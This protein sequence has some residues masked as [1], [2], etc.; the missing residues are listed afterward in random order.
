MTWLWRPARCRRRRSIG[1]SR[2]RKQRG[3]L[4]TEQGRRDQELALAVGQTGARHSR[5]GR[6]PARRPAAS[7]TSAAVA[8]SKPS[9][10]ARP[11]SRLTGSPEQLGGGRVGLDHLVARGIDDQHRLGGHLEQQAVA[12]LD[13]PQPG[14][15][16]LHRLLRVDQPLLQG[17]HGAQVA[18]DRHD[19]ARRRRPAASNRGPG[20]R[21]RAARDG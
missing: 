10:K 5:P 2:T 16:A 20:G 18:A 9:G 1:S 11:T 3:V 6:S 21:R 12:G 19:T 8:G 15:V 7:R 13:M 4:L 14:V 17:R